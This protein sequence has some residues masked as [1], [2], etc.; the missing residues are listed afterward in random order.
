MRDVT[1]EFLR[2]VQTSHTMA[3]RIDSYR[4]VG[5]EMELA[6]ADLPVREARTVWDDSATLKRTL[7]LTV[8]SQDLTPG[9]IRS[10]DPYGDPT[11]PLAN[12]GQQLHVQAGIDLPS[13]VTELVNL[14][15]YLITEWELSEDES[16]VQ[17]HAV[18]LTQAVADLPFPRAT[19][20]TGTTHD[21]ITSVI[22]T[23]GK[24]TVQIDPDVPGGTWERGFVFEGDRVDAV[25]S[26]LTRMHARWYTD[27]TGTVRISRR[28]GPVDQEPTVLDFRDGDG[29]TVLR[30]L[31]GGDR[32]R[33]PNY[34]AVTGKTDGNIPP[35]DI[36]RVETGPYSV[37]SYG[38][39]AEVIDVDAET[40]A[41]VEQ[42]AQERLQEN[43]TRS[44]VVVFDTVPN[45][46]LQLGDV[47]GFSSARVQ[48]KGRVQKIDMPLTPGDPMR[49]TISRETQSA[50][51]LGSA[52]PAES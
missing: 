18:D 30:S 29:G 15:W 48:T 2:A 52:E 25:Q 22:Q 13:G 50:V 46:A 12:F 43:I 19:G 41:E 5:T 21:V 16:E 34:V 14:G 31:D 26:L 27:D 20:Y 9:G 36:E 8:P 3:L 47:V 32:G 4:P 11:A 37:F 7:D 1:D 38:Y 33:V 49:V 45:P 39:V 23:T 24:L 17:V 51:N 35:F 42:I 6:Y 28:Y 44:E 40:Q 10:L